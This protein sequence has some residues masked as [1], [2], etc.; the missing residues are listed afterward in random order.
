MTQPNESHSSLP[1]SPEVPPSLADKAPTSMQRAVMERARI[2]AEPSRFATKPS[3][4][5]WIIALLLATIPVFV[6]FALADFVLRVVH[7]IV[8]RYV[9]A[10]APA[11]APA[12][13]P[14]AADPGVVLLQPYSG[15]A[16]TPSGG[17]AAAPSPKH[18]PPAQN[19]T[20]HTPQRSQ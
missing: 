10:T 15:A 9:P 7:T 13:P 20:A 12:Q 1:A 17:S 14:A 16:R 11:P 18:D 6:T 5:L 2:A 8:T 3:L 19:E 4:R